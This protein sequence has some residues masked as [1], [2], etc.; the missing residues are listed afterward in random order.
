MP[1]LFF[2]VTQA[3]MS[4]W[5][6]VDTDKFARA[7]GGKG[8][9]WWTRG[10]EHFQITFS[11]GSV[12]LEAWVEVTVEYPLRPPRFKLFL[13]KGLPDITSTSAAA[14]GGALVKATAN[15]EVLAQV[16]SGERGNM[17]VN[18]LNDIEIEVNN[19]FPC[20]LSE[21]ADQEASFQLSK[22][23]DEAAC[24][25]YLLSYQLRKLQTCLDLL[26]E[27]RKNQSVRF[28]EALR[29]PDRRKPFV[30]GSHSLYYARS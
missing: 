29:G 30:F 10:A 12:V 6:R 3:V 9:E 24:S 13:P 27:A 4:R 15:A 25:Q 7:C 18:D 22:S 8:E 21:F 26:V 28:L 20:P 11:R 2:N 23:T 17:F 1:Y 14:S 16:A 5:T 19:H